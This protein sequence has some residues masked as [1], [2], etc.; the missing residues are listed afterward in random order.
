MAK[1]SVSTASAF[2]AG[3]EPLG[4]GIDLAGRNGQSMTWDP[5]IGMVLRNKQGKI[6]AFC[7]PTKV[8]EPDVVM[9]GLS[10]SSIAT[11]EKCE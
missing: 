6:T 4:K 8:G 10:D 9:V 2:F 7:P 11:F 1:K 3:K 5:S